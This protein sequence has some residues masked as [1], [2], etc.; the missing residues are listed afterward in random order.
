M[1][2]KDN[3]EQFI[4]ERRAA[5]DDKEPPRM[6]WDKIQ[7]KLNKDNKVPRRISLWHF[8]RIAATVAI[9]VGIG[10]V[11]GRYS[12][13]AT[14]TAYV[15]ENFPEF[16]EAQN[17]FQMEVDERLARLA[18]Y[19][20]DAGLQDDMVQLDQFME[21]L[22]AELQVA[23]KGSEDKIIQAMISNYQTKLDILER[24]LKSVE[25]N[26]LNKTNSQKNET[27]I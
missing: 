3:L 25:D 26:N 15:E 5:F 24:V 18:S 1:M 21:E 8:T 6:A 11:I 12:A 27:D 22:K 2:N 20:Y 23:P 7:Q 19:S 10:M 13:P 4:R 14:E 16:V 17:Y 9:L